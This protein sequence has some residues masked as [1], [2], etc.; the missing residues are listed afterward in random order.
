MICARCADL[1]RI[2]AYNTD[3]IKVVNPLPIKL[4]ANPGLGGIRKESKASLYGHGLDEIEIHRTYQEPE[5]KLGVGALVTGPPGCGKSQGLA[6]LWRIGESKVLGIQA[7]YERKIALAYTR[8]GTTNLK[9]RGVDYV[10]T[11]DKLL[12]S[13][14]QGKRRLDFDAIFVDEFSMVPKSKMAFLWKLKQ[15]KPDVAIYCFGDSDQCKA[16]EKDGMWYEYLHSKMIGHL[17]GNR[18]ITLEYN[19]ATGRYDASM[20]KNLMTFKKTGIL[21][22]EMVRGLFPDSIE[23]LY[24]VRDHNA[25]TRGNKKISELYM[26]QT[27]KPAVQITNKKGV[28][29]T[30]AA[31]MPLIAF[32]NLNQTIDNG[33]RF[34]IVAIDK[35]NATIR[36]D[37]DRVE[38]EVSLDDFKKCLRHGWYE[39]VARFQGAT[40]TKKYNIVWDPKMS[41]N[42]LYTA[43]SRAKRIEDVGL[44]VPPGTFHKRDRQPQYSR[45]V[46]PGGEDAKKTVIYRLTDH[47]GNTYVGETTR[48]LEERFEEHKTKPTCAKMKKWLNENEVKAEQLFEFLSPSDQCTRTI[49]RRVVHSVPSHLR[50][51]TTFGNDDKGIGE[52]GELLQRLI[53]SSFGMGEVPGIETSRY[54]ISEN[55]T[56]HCFRIQ[57]DEEGKKNEKSVSWG[58]KRTKEEAFREI[59]KIRFGLLLTDIYGP[60]RFPDQTLEGELEF[61]FDD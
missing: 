9:N 57:W 2:C 23:L 4:E 32:D 3:S 58:R 48:T 44:E 38:L 28:V 60:Q 27:K 20:Y 25:R 36:R 14:K 22:R 39:T 56:K 7:D 47:K 17:T 55:K 43:I 49:E 8:N 40:V 35:T 53:K 18:V 5:R 51:N 42:E 31:G 41:W 1:I 11:F 45:E 54:R 50:M 15:E 59:S 26:Q 13:V 52:Q 12:E 21:P 34:T 24:I 30:Y 29:E 10:M 61:E 16:I 37:H 6:D 46:H 19:P 33:D